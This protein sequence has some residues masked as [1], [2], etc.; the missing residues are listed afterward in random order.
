MHRLRIGYGSSNPVLGRR[1]LDLMNMPDNEVKINTKKFADGE[2]C[3]DYAETVRGC[4]L[5]IIQPVCGP[6]VNSALME[7]LLMIDAARRADAAKV[8]AVIPY[9]GYAR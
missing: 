6:N 9:Y 2:I 3:V 7:L 8:T 5:F 1:V 4:D